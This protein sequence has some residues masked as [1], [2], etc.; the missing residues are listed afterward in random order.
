MGKNGEQKYEVFF[1]LWLIYQEGSFHKR[2]ARLAR[3][4]DHLTY[5]TRHTHKLSKES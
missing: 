4:R 3:A 2:I 1:K 5:T